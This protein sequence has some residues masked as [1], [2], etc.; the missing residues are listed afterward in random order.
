MYESEYALL[1]LT[2]ELMVY[3]FP[4]RIISMWSEIVSSQQ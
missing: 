3:F 4:G 1:G 2:V